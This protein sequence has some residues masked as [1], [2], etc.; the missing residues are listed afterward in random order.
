MNPDIEPRPGQAHKPIVVRDF[1][2]AQ[3]ELTLVTGP[4]G[5]S[6][7]IR[8][9]TVNRPGLL[10]S[11][12][13]EYFAEHRVQVM[14]SV[15]MHYLNSLPPDTRRARLAAFFTRPIPCLVLCRDYQPDA[16]IRELAEAAGIPVF[17][18][19][20]VTM[21][22]ISRATLALEELFAPVETRHGSMVDILGI[23]VLIMGDPGIGKSECAIGL[24]ERGYALVADDLTRLRLRNGRHLIGTCPEAG[25][26]Y[27][28]VR[29]IGIVDVPAMFGVKAL[30]TEKQLDLVVTLKHWEDVKE[31]E[32]VGDCVSTLQI[33]GVP[34]PHM[35]IPIRP[36]RDVARLVEV[37]AFHTKLR[38]LGYNPADALNQA[39]LASM[40]PRGG[41]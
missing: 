15:E 26:N 20:E 2:T 1:L 41:G 8:E 40:R 33:L 3:P 5:L 24:I 37:G 31:I 28:E 18:S 29:G 13:N 39:V 12:F 27:M 22:F 23:G 11:G 16:V 32:R 35:T 25:R 34:V 7:P 9:P 38:V 17:V 10:L 4:Q 6:R 36:G 14:G 19:P 21:N 30:R